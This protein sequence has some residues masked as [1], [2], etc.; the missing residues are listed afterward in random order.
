[1][2]FIARYNVIR[3]IRQNYLLSTRIAMYHDT[4]YGESSD[5]VEPLNNNS[6]LEANTVER[7][8]GRSARKFG[9]Y[10]SS[11]K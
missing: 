5:D 1:M 9:I 11:S 3:D 6:S 10:T 7:S 8:H 2:T 4:S